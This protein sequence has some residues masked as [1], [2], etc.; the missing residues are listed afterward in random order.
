M[1]SSLRACLAAES[2]KRLWPEENRG[3]K[4]KPKKLCFEL[5]AKQSFKV[6]TLY[7]EQAL[8]ILNYSPELRQSAAGE[9]L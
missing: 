7:A 2:W 9:L 5:F 6:N 4:A 8:A 3:G 1:T